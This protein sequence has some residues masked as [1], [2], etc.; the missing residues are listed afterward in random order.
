MEDDSRISSEQELICTV[1]IRDV[2][3]IIHKLLF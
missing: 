2:E 3:N 1:P